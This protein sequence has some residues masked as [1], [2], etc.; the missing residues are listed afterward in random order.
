[1]KKRIVV[2]AGGSGSRLWPY[3]RKQYP[4]QILK[5]V[6]DKTLLQDTCLRF[7]SNQE[8]VS[9]VTNSQQRFLVANNLAEIGYTKQDL[10]IE[11]P[12]P[13]NTAPAICLAAL[14]FDDDDIM[15]VLPSDHIISSQGRFNAAIDRACMFAEKEQLVTI[16]VKPNYPETG[17]G[18]MRKGSPF[19]VG[20]FAVDTFVEKPSLE[21][22]EEYL[23]SGDYLWNCGIFVWKVS[24]L[25]YEFKK[26]APEVYR[27]VEAY[28]KTGDSK[29][30][31]TVTSISI[32]Y[33]LL[34]K[35]K[36][37]CVVEGTFDW[38][39]LGSWQAIYDFYE[40]DENGNIVNGLAL[41]DD[42]KNTYV[43]N[44]S[45]DRLVAVIGMENCTIIDTDDA[46]LICESSRAQDVKQIVDKLKKQN[47]DKI[48]LHKTVHRPWGYYKVLE[49]TDYFKSKRL[50]VYPDQS[51][52][53]Q[54]HQKRNETWT[55]VKGVAKVTYG[56]TTKDLG[57]GE[58]I[59]IPANTVHRLANMTNENVELIEV[60]TGSYFGE[61][62]II[63]LEDKY[64]RE[65]D[66]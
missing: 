65:K 34:E 12:Y 61:D 18:Y 25:L 30:F 52:S 40:K 14:Q 16:G 23:K 42:S 41:V 15:I 59:Y 60:Q 1:M 66:V 3:S 58:T 29:Y 17:Y 64:N 24:T 50:V 9:V 8:N 57:V 43:H 13:R 46:L 4:K 48:N 51:I 21:V 32:D 36:N 49:D 20:G 53:L 31:D 10:I 54:Y 2:L 63:R 26:Y 62:D 6:G 22:A 47:P 5:L 39:D 19:E 44:T 11:E 38:S 27:Q 56:N 37:I 55:V 33:A 7:G 45:D 35:S 28:Y